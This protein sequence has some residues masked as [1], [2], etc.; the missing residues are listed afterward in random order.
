MSSGNLRVEL[1]STPTCDVQMEHSY[2]VRGCISSA[3]SQ[4]NRSLGWFFKRPDTLGQRRRVCV[5]RCQHVSKAIREYQLGMIFLLSC[6]VVTLIHYISGE[7]PK[8]TS[9]MS[10][11][12]MSWLIFGI[13]IFCMPPFC[14][15][16]SF[17]LNLFQTF[18]RATHSAHRPR[19]WLQTDARSTEWTK[20]APFQCIRPEA[21][22][23]FRYG[24]Y[25]ICQRYHTDCWPFK[26]THNTETFRR[27]SGVV[28]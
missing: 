19:G 26:N 4:A 22:F 28:L 5:A 21:Y 17:D 24:Y 23:V 2:L 8:T 6:C 10:W 1:E 12:A 9:K 11:L 16:V 18:K 25:E 7:R 3:F 27:P 15:A 13:I 14:S 20:Y